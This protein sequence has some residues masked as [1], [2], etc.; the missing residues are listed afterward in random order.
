[1]SVKNDYHWSI[2]IINTYSGYFEL[3]LKQDI[4]VELD[5]VFWV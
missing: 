5:H 4:E 3:I 2:L 1:M